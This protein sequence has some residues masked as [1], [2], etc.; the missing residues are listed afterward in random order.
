MT[1]TYSWRGEFENLEY[2]TLHADA[3]GA[4]EA[5]RNADWQSLL[6]VH[7]LGWITA[8]KGS[9]LVGFVNVVWDGRAHA[10]I[11]DVMVA[12]TVRNEGIGTQLV[13]V[14][15]NASAQSGCEWLHVDDEERLTSFYV[16]ACG[17]T[18]SSAGVI[19]LK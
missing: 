4:N 10:W 7:S 12:P 6:S 14:A 18:P 17:F 16:N 3:F 15:R 2:R 5:E 9:E 13:S 8:R 1:I 19:H 11:Q